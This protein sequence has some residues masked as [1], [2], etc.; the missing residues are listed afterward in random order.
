MK[1]RKKA[2]LLASIASLC[3][4]CGCGKEVIEIEGEQY[5][6]SGAAY[7]K[8]ALTPKVFAPGKHIVRYVEKTSPGVDSSGWGTVVMNI[9]EV[10]E[11]YRYVETLT[12]DTGYNGLSNGFVHIFINE[13]RVEAK[14]SYNPKTNTIEYLEPG[15][16]IEEQRVLEM[17]D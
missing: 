12:I 11:G 3:I 15:V 16:V 9:P 7:P 10:P 2:I 4:L 13:K 1:N 17:G 8:L 14:P 5:V 6:K